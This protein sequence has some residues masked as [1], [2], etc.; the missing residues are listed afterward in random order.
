VYVPARQTSKSTG[1][2]AGVFAT[3]QWSVVVRA[4]DNRSPEAAAA[5]ERLHRTAALW[6]V[7]EGAR[8]DKN[9][10]ITDGMI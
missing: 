4:G 1:A 2:G 3:T 9:Q 6:Q 7:V 8:L 10:P 5:M